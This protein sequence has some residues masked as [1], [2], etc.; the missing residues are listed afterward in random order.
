MA[1]EPEKPAAGVRKIDWDVL[2]AK[3]AGPQTPTTRYQFSNGRKFL[4]FK[5]QGAYAPEEEDP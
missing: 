1:E 2:V 5:D 3:I 4:N